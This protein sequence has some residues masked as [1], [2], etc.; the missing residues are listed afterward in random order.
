MDGPEYE[1]AGALGSLL[2][3]FDLQAVIHANHLCNLY[4]MDVISLGVT[5]ALACELFERGLLTALRH[6]RAGD[7]LRRRRDGPT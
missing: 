1:A 7:P 6:G 5:L 2:M 4:G 3:I